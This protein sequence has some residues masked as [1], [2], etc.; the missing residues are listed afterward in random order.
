[1]LQKYSKSIVTLIIENGKSV[2]SN[3]IKK[4]LDNIELSK[5]L[6]TQDPNSIPV[7]FGYMRSTDQR[8]VV[9]L[10][11]GPKTSTNNIYT[12]AYYKETTY[13]LEN[14][15]E[16]IDRKESRVPFSNT[17][18]DVFILNHFY[19]KSCNINL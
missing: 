15:Q 2:D 4:A 11:N 7:T 10:E 16:C 14:D 13:S 18:V 6:L 12:T 3:K 9:F 8:L 17:S 1:M 5:Y 19:S